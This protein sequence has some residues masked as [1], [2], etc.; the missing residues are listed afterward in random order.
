[1]IKRFLSILA[2]VSTLTATAQNKDLYDKDLLSK[3]FHQLRREALRQQMPANSVA[4]FF[5]S[6]ERNRANDINY[7]YH[8]DP[9]FFYFSGFNETN[10]ILLVFKDEQT[11]GGIKANDFIFVQNRDPKS[12]LWTGRRLGKEGVMKKLGFTGVLLS[13]DFESATI[14]F[15]SMAMIMVKTLPKGLVDEKNEKADLY[16][17]VEQFK[18]KSGYPKVENI[19][20]V[21]ITKATAELR[22]HKQPEELVLLRK[23]INITCVAITELMK[24]LEPSMYEYQA[25][26]MVEYVFTN[27]GS[28]YTGYPC[29]VGGGENSCI[30][31]YESN[32]KELEAKDI[33]VADVGAEYHGYSADVTRSL[34]VD[35]NYSIEEKAIYN[36]V[37]KAQTAGIEACKKGNGFGKPGYEATEIIKKGLKDLGII[38]EESDYRKYFPHGTSHYIGLDVHDAGTYSDLSLGDVITVEPGIYI[39]SGS[40]CDPKWWNIGVRIEDD[41]LITDT[42][43]ENL[44]ACVPRTIEEIEAVM[45]QK[46]LF[47][48]LSK[49]KPASLNR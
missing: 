21:L 39:P 47:N 1:M 49:L 13:D 30:L 38:K 14:N 16:D 20:Q 33:M 23:A 32:R 17:L 12:E 42:G 28:E 35:G 31:H 44:S 40:D 36:L 3:E 9:D 22:Q 4:V 24:G 45:K 27:N 48:D 19:D 29:I 6:P 34:P 37:L 25:Q 46:S 26:A 18:L 41:I 43:Y 11:I 2:C 8:Q 5:A 15:K 10:S 7:L